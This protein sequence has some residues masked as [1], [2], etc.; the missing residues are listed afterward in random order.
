MK[1]KTACAGKIKSNQ[2]YRKCFP[3]LVIDKIS[4]LPAIPPPINT[5]FS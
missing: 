3:E 2:V 5:I 1:M 4:F